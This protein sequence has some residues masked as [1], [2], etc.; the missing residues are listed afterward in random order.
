MVVGVNGS[1][2]LTVVS[3]CFIVPRIRRMRLWVRSVSLIYFMCEAA[4]FWKVLCE[5]ARRTIRSYSE[6]Q[7]FNCQTRTVMWK[8]Q[9]EVLC[10][11]ANKPFPTNPCTHWPRRSQ[12]GSSTSTQSSRL[13]LAHVVQFLALDFHIRAESDSQIMAV[14]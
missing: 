8:G 6:N 3:G 14:L 11:I 2:M 1:M 13:S 7:T 9:L 5:N 12:S 4:H 10:E